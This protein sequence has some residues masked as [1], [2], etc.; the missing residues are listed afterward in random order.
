MKQLNNL[1]HIKLG[2]VEKK[3]LPHY[4]FYILSIPL[5]VPLLIS[6]FISLSLVVKNNNLLFLIL[7]V[8]AMSLI[9]KVFWNNIKKL[10]TIFHENMHK[11]KANKMG[12]NVTI[13]YDKDKLERIRRK[14]GFNEES[15]ALCVFEEGVSFKKKDLVK[16]YLSP[17]KWIV[18]L[19]LLMT[20]IVPFLLYFSITSSILSLIPTYISLLLFAR[21]EGCINDFVCYVQIRMK[22]KEIYKIV[23]KDYNFIM[24]YN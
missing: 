10:I 21:L 3:G 9:T 20:F 13:I 14:R 11:M 23:Y 16:I 19:I 7:V 18:G 4:L 24:Y 1:P 22:W 15:N 17:Y 6:T 5:V 8:F 2:I 12:Y